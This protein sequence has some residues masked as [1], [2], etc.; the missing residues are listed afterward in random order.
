MINLNRRVKALE[1]RITA[2]SDRWPLIITCTNP[3]AKRA[4]SL[5]SHEILPGVYAL[6]YGGPLTTDELQELRARYAAEK[7]CS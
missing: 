1:K 4:E 3:N 2:S 5:Q 6:A 7:R